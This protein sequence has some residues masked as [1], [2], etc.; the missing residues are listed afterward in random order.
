MNAIV[1]YCLHLAIVLL[2]SIV[3]DCG[4]ASVTT[5]D[6]GRLIQLG[7]ANRLGGFDRETTRYDFV[8]NPISTELLHTTVADTVGILHKVGVPT[9]RIKEIRDKIPGIVTGFGSYR[10]WTIQEQNKAIECQKLDN[11]RLSF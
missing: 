7:V 5:I 2:M 4:Y 8:G 10:P 11:Y 9:E 6:R 1:I 3:A